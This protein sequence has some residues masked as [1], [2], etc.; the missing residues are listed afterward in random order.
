MRKL[1][2]TLTGVLMTLPL[3]ALG[4]T[5]ADADQAEREPTAWQR[6]QQATDPD[7]VAIRQVLEILIQDRRPAAR[8]A[9]PEA[10]RVDPTTVGQ[11]RALEGRIRR[12]EGE[13]TQ[14]RAQVNR[15]R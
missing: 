10:G 5:T 8:L 3:Y 15:L 11:T 6:L 14:L 2:I 7:I 9:Q 1:L 4:A 13:I 12:L